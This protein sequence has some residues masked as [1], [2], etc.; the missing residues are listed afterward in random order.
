MG[1]FD[2]GTDISGWGWPEWS[3]VALGG[4]IGFN[5][6]RSVARTGRSATKG[7]KRYRRRA[8]KRRALKQQVQQ[9]GWF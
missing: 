4:L 5:F 6:L 7:I 8:A 9:T 1:L 2:S 3:I